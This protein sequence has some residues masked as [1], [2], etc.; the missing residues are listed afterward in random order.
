VGY[1]TGRQPQGLD[2]GQLAVRGLR[3]DEGPQ[4][5][6]G[7]VDT[8]GTVEREQ[9]TEVTPSGAELSTAGPRSAEPVKSNP[10]LNN[11]QL[12]EILKCSIVES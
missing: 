7:R 12:P 1:V 8:A 6:E 5:R 3:G 9:D 4:H 10:Q 11:L 2:L